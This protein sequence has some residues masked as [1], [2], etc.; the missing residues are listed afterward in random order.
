LRKIA[1]PRRGLAAQ[2][3]SRSRGQ[4]STGTGPRGLQ[5]PPPHHQRPVSF[6]IPSLLLA[7]LTGDNSLWSF[8]RLMPRF[9]GDPPTPQSVQWWEI[10]GGHLNFQASGLLRTA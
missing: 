1:A 4:L 3:G 10:L 7:F 9:G 2:G 6:S 8:V 5:S